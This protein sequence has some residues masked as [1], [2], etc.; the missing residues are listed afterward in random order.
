MT[1]DQQVRLL[2]TLFK[3]G[4]P[5]VTAAAKAGMS[6][7][8]ARKY[9]RLGKVPSE[10]RVA[11]TWRTR[12]DPFE[13]VWAEV[14]VL[15]EQDKGL[16]AKTVFEELGRRYPGRFE[17]GQLRTLQRR[18]RDYS[19][20]RLIRDLMPESGG[21]RARW[22]IDSGI[23]TGCSGM[24]VRRR[25]ADIVRAASVKVQFWPLPAL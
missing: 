25:R 8:T 12:A 18:F 21:E 14:E 24:P 5:V 20:I 3:R 6:E 2:M 22:S 19:R 4:L 13:E 9:R 17:A 23:I 15:L 10:L 7:G 11:H 1:T 16:Q